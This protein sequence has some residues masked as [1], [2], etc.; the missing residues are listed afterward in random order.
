MRKIVVYCEAFSGKF[1]PIS[2]ELL[3][4]ARE[5]SER[6]KLHVVALF[7]AERIV[8]DPKK[9]IWKGADEVYA[10]LG[11]GLSAPDPNLH[12][13][14]VLDFLND[15]VS[16]LMFPATPFGRVL[17]PI[18]AAKAGAGLTADCTDLRVDELGRIV[19][20]RPAFSG[21]VLAEI[22]TEKPPVMCTVRYHVFK[23][24]PED[25]SRKGEV[26]E[27]Q[28]EPTPNGV[29]FQ[30]RVS[31]D[32]VN[33]ADAKII[34]SVG[35]GLKSKEDLKEIFEIAEMI[36]AKVG[37]SRPLV[38]DG[39]LSKEHQVG[40]SGNVVKPKLYIALGISGSPQHLAGMRDSEIIFAVNKDPSAPIRRHSDYFVLG[41]LYEFLRELKRKIEKGGEVKPPLE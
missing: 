22:V 33:L 25:R 36:G 14:A 19:Q 1:H 39:W 27:V 13:Q 7:S 9:L 24:L 38:D 18:V 20:V 30:E 17:A 8:E 6:L 41:D 23:E 37:A 5:L 32:K 10:Y 26:H 4:K 12:S 11:K 3:G 35:R 28:F 15:E 34:L 31:E 21:N 40:F 29:S 2:Y 16:C